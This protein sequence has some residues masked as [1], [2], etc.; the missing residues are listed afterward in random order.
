MTR[1]GPEYLQRG[2]SP[3]RLVSVPFSS[4]QRCRRCFCS[5]TS[6]ADEAATARA[7]VSR[8]AEN[9]RLETLLLLQCLKFVPDLGGSWFPRREGPKVAPARP[10][11]SQRSLAQRRPRLGPLAI[12][13]AAA[14]PPAPQ[15]HVLRPPPLSQTRIRT[16]RTPMG[17]H[18]QASAA[19]GPV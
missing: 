8:A 2:D 12:L 10:V 17:A 15:L 1:V 5:K 4:C 3:P 16:A 18:T 19:A 13:D 14:H 7:E 6:R 9:C 11:P